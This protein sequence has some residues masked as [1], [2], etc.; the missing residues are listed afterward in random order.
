MLSWRQAELRASVYTTLQETSEPGKGKG[1]KIYLENPMYSDIRKDDTGM[2]RLFRCRPI[3]PSNQSVCI[4]SYFGITF[5][6]RLP[7]DLWTVKQSRS[8]S[9]RSRSGELT[10]LANGQTWFRQN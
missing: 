4:A 3:W 10:L 2:L 9:T 1:E 6:A 5:G 8:I 7:A